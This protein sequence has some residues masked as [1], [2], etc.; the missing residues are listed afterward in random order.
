MENIIVK[1][2]EWPNNGEGYQYYAEMPQ[3]PGLGES[4]RSAKEA[5]DEL[6]KSLTVK[7]MFDNELD[8]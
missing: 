6:I 8:F 2:T 5:F 3:Y 7:I 1:I 4:G